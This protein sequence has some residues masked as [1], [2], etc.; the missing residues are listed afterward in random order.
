MRIS[1]HFRIALLIALP[2]VVFLLTDSAADESKNT[3]NQNSEYKN[4]T[5]EK[6]HASVHLNENSEKKQWGI[7]PFG[8]HNSDR[9]EIQP[10]EVQIE[11]PD[12][13]SPTDTQLAKFW[14]SGGLTFM[15]PGAEQL[16]REILEDPGKSKI[17]ALCSSVLEMKQSGSATE[18]VDQFKYGIN[19]ILYIDSATGRKEFL[20]DRVEWIQKIFLD[21]EEPIISANNEPDSFLWQKCMSQT[22]YQTLLLPLK[23]NFIRMTK[24][25]IARPFSDPP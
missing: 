9:V 17:L 23:R 7:N 2:V 6:S 12:P 20:L 11:T 24:L 25:Y 8:E 21:L 16:M 15:Q 18:Y 3:G 14:A 1:S 5:S 4:H 10:I 13:E 19:D 22:D